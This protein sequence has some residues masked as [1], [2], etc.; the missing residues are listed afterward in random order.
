MRYIAKGSADQSVPLFI[1]SNAVADGSGLTGLTFE[2]AGLTAYYKRGATGTPTQITLATLANGQAAHSDGGFVAV[3][4]TNMPGH[5]RLDL[6]DAAVAEG[7]DYLIVMLKGAA[8][9]VPVSILVEL[10][11]PDVH[12]PAYVGAYSYIKTATTDQYLITVFLNGVPFTGTITSPTLTVIDED[13]STVIDGEALAAVAGTPGLLYSAETT[14]RIAA[15]KTFSVRV[16]ATI[17]GSARV[18]HCVPGG[19]NATS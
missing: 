5:Y 11:G 3:D 14:E 15:G 6:P 17:N 2:S 7:V 12:A 16:N 19:Q 10:T 8:N 1:A 9:M 4:G 13:E 18:I